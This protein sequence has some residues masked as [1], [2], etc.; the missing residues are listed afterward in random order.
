MSSSCVCVCSPG[1]A[2]A[3]DGHAGDSQRLFQVR[4]ASSLTSLRWAF[5][6]VEEAE[7]E[8]PACQAPLRQTTCTLERGHADRLASGAEAGGEIPVLEEA[9]PATFEKAAAPLCGMA[10]ASGSSGTATPEVP[11][12]GTARPGSLGHPDLCTKPCVKIVAG[13]CAAGDDCP[14]CHLPHP[15]RPVHFNQEKRRTLRRKRPY[16]VQAL[17]LP[18]LREKVL[19]FDESA[20]TR[21]VLDLLESRCRPVH[22]ATAGCTSRSLT[23]VMQKMNIRHL[24]RVF[25]HY[26]VADDADACEIL[27]RLTDH[28]LL[29]SSVG[30]RSGATNRAA[31]ERASACTQLCTPA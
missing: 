31:Q 19:A 23:Q 3:D 25:S 6:D 17:M 26:A 16:E 9:A 5:V 7:C 13:L 2:M 10:A 14:Y 29:L 22:S 1:H 15:C 27:D 30:C 24:C 11:L 20:N 4:N 8:R 12:A 18:V 21:E 28:L